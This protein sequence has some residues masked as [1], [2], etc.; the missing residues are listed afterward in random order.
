[1][2]RTDDAFTLIEVMVVVLVV[3]ILIAIGLPMFLGAKL[4]A[5]ERRA[6]EGLHSAQVAGLVYWTQGGTFTAFDN[7]CTGIPDSCDVADAEEGSVTWIG[8]GAPAL[9]EVSIVLAAG[10]SMLLVTR[11]TSGE[12]FCIAQATGQSDRGR[13]P[14]FSDVDSIPECAGGW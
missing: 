3:G 2:L 5:E 8:P 11:A 7:N 9:G 13:G 10:N 1:M 14:A 4:R 12:L 6:Q